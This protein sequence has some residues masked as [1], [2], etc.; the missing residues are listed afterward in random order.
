MSKGTEIWGKRERR[1]KEG[2]ICGPR[3]LD[4]PRTQHLLPEEASYEQPQ[5]TERT[6]GK[7]KKVVDDGRR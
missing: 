2:H 5:D 7:Q 3:A 1:E 4:Q 6:I